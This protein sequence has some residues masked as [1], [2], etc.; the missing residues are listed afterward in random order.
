MR[1]VFSAPTGPGFSTNPKA[2]QLPA[3]ELMMW[4]G[5]RPA[6]TTS[7]AATAWMMALQPPPQ[8]TNKTFPYLLVSSDMHMLRFVD[9]A[10]TLP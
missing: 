4:E 10:C 9:W 1:I 6:F 7:E 5:V 3:E 8:N 2:L